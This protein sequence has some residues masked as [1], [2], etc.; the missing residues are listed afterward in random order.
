MNSFDAYK[1]FLAIKMHFNSDTYDYFKY[2]GSTRASLKSFEKRKDKYF[3]QKLS[4]KYDDKNLK[5][6]LV[7]NFF[8][9]DVWIG[10]LFNEKCYKRYMSMKAR[11]EKIKHLFQEDIDQ[12]LLLLE[13]NNLE[14]KSLFTVP[15]TGHPLLLKYYLSRKISVETFLIFNEMF[16]FFTLWD[17][18]IQDTVIWPEVKKKCLKLSPFLDIITNNKKKFVEITAS[19][20][21]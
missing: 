1:Q 18:K 10:N 5:S 3:F 14:L 4:D 16:D 17:T 11:H 6:Y 21:L 2:N 9:E 12:L 15:K 19:K 8:E 13:Q 20:I 7:S